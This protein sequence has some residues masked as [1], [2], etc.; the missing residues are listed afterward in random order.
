MSD[1]GE[2]SSILSL[3]V[4]HNHSDRSIGLCQAGKIQEILHTSLTRMQSQLER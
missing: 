4:I 2:A 3:K 1:L